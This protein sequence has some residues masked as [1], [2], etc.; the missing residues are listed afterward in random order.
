MSVL[1]S[2]SLF[3]YYNERQDADGTPLFWPGGPGGLPFRG[4]APG[5]ISQDEYERLQVAGVVRA[6]TFFMNNEE[7]VK[8]YCDV[9]G[10]AVNG[11]FAI[12]DRV[13]RWDDEQRC[14]RIFLEWAELAYGMPSGTAGPMEG[15]SNAISGPYAVPR[16]VFDTATG[17]PP[18]MQLEQMR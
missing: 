1:S 4:R 12:L 15:P 7:D 8:Q 6:R 2:P 9:R 17:F 11:M 14:E 13:V 5:A 10:K 16:R 18:G 3:L